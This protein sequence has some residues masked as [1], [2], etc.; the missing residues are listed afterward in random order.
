MS[1][2]GRPKG[3]LPEGAALRYP[4]EPGMAQMLLDMPVELPESLLQ[5][6]AS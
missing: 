1:P 3:E 2:P 4:S 5:E 6:L